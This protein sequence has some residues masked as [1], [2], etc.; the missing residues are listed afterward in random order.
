ML[1][2]DIKVT[3]A[4]AYCELSASVQ[5]ETFWVWGSEPFKLW[6]RYPAEF[7]RYLDEKNGNPF[8]PAFL[9]PARVLGEPLN[10]EAEVSPRLAASTAEVQSL[11]RSWY[12]SLSRVDVNASIRS[13]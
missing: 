13:E 8:L 9:G 6:I 7:V 4:G 11:Y 5:C 1:V 10:I 2:T 12:P 3:N